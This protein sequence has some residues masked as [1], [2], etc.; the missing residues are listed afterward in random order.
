MDMKEIR[1][2]RLKEWFAG[3]KLPQKDSSYISQVINGKNIGEKAARRLEREN[4]MPDMFLDTPFDIEQEEKVVLTEQQKKVL[5]LLDSLPDD[6][7]DEFIL[8]ISERVDFY[9]KR[10]KQLYG[11]IITDND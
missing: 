9:N 2:L 11:K 3:R 7:V 5:R 10:L 6:E 8:K 4:G 1:R